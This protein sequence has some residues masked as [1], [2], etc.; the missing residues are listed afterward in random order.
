MPKERGRIVRKWNRN[1]NQRITLTL[2]DGR[3]IVIDC[4]FAGR[5]S[6]INKIH[7]DAPLD[8]R[9][10]SKTIHIDTTEPAPS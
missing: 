10:D 9:I 2:P 8:V 7:I 4:G 1:S 6:S 5:K 3:E